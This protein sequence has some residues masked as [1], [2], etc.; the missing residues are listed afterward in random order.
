M[1]IRFTGE[2]EE[3]IKRLYSDMLD[4]LSMVGIPVE[5][6]PSDRRRE[7]MAGACLATGQIISSFKQAKSVMNGSFLKTRD[8]IS[9]E[10]THY[11]EHISP[12]SDRKSVGRERV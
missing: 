3:S 10:N 11:G 1:R 8:I 4:I 6:L 9:F 7:K 2:K 5:D 12:G